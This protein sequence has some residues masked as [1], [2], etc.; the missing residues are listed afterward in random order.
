MSEM[1]V[2]A[3]EA[4]GSDFKTFHH[5]VIKR[6]ELR[7]DDVAIDIKYC[8]ICH[9]DIAIVE[10][11]DPVFKRPIVPGHEISGV[12]SAVGEKVTKYK[13]GDRVGV[14]CFIDSCGKCKYCLAGEEQFCEKGVISVFVGDDYDGRP[15]EGGYSQAIVVKERFV[16]AIPDKLDLAE[17]SPLL[18]A[19]ITTYNPLKRYGITT[20]SRVA[21]V[22]LG[23][24]GH[25]ATQFAS[26]MGANVTVFGH[27]ETK[28]N[29]A[30][31]FGASSYE[32]LKTPEDFKRF[33]G[34]FDFLLST[35]AVKLDWNAYL[36]LLDVKGIACSVGLPNEDQ[37]LNLQVMF[38]RQNTLTVSNVG[39]ISLTQEMLNFAA[40]HE[41]HP[42]IEMIGIDDVPEAYERILNSDVHYRFVIDMSTLQ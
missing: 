16:L 31:Q 12:V 2:A 38:D 7:A 15:T 42:K 33:D 1:Q 24:L 29:E 39:G 35:V 27:S 34:Q 17:A 37:A 6:R 41:V 32:I 40:E 26:K 10:G 9:S 30:K 18:C 21:I 28:A 36:R 25:I 20:G 8:G 4:T 23:G 22:G 11:I 19:G 5:T 13:V 3:L 14:G